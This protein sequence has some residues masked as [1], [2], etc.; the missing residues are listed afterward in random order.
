M[1]EDFGRYWPVYQAAMQGDWNTA[2]NFFPDIKQLSTTVISSKSETALHIAVLIGKR[3]QDFVKRL[4]DLAPPEALALKDS[5][6]GNTPLQN[7]ALVGNTEAAKA[8]V[9][10]N[11][12]L[13][14]ILTSMRWLPVHE[15]AVSSQKETLEYLLS[16]HE[17][18]AKDRPLFE[19]QIGIRVLNGII[20]SEFVGRS[21][22]NYS[23]MCVLFT[24]SIPFM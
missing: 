24:P 1:E 22:L 18:L 9:K 12:D 6:D 15:A 2:K 3:N 7:A 5:Y 14:Y 23:N 4:V 13:L 8:M 19:G 17:K 20:A 10:K 21:L 11:P 16:E